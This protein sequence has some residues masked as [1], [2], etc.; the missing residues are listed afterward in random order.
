MSP[1]CSRS[2]HSSQPSSFP[3]SAR[4]WP[5]G[6]CSAGVWPHADEEADASHVTAR[7]VSHVLRLCRLPTARSPGSTHKDCTTA[8]QPPT[9]ILLPGPHLRTSAGRS[10]LHPRPMHKVPPRPL[11]CRPSLWDSAPS[12]TLASGRTSLTL[13]LTIR[14]SC[15]ASRTPSA[16]ATPKR[17]TPLP[18]CP[19]Y[20]IGGMHSP[21]NT[22]ISP[23]PANPPSGTIPGVLCNI[24]AGQILQAGLGW[25][26]IFILSAMLDFIGA[27]T[28]GMFA[29]AEVQVR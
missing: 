10:S 15:S 25:R 13:P 8:T 19:L 12:V 26:P 28:F 2:C 16:S 1:G 4:V 11:P 20:S 29:R 22:H 14:A 18:F 9:A 24:V 5:I 6:A 3:T 17:L 23:R 27:V 7:Q 21:G